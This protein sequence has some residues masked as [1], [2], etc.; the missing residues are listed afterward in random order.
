MELSSQRVLGHSELLS[1]FGRAKVVPTTQ[2]LK[3]MT[4]VTTR[5]SPEN[6]L[7]ASYPSH[8]EWHGQGDTGWPVGPTIN[9]TSL[10]QCPW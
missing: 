3:T 9:E 8:G 2:A 5:V 10:P 4:L 6:S 1:Q 7:G